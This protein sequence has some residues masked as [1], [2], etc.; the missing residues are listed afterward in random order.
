MID[1]LNKIKTILEM[2][3]NYF[4]PTLLTIISGLFSLIPFVINLKKKEKYKL[5]NLN[6]IDDKVYLIC[7]IILFVEIFFSALFVWISANIA[8]SLT[9]KLYQKG[10]SEMRLK[11]V[12]LCIFSIFFLII[13]NIVFLIILGQNFI[14]KI[15]STYKYIKIFTYIT[16]YAYYIFWMAY[17]IFKQ[18]YI[19]LFIEFCLISWSYWTI[20]GIDIFQSDEKYEYLY[21][22][23]FLN[24][25][26]I[27]KCD[28]MKNID[29]IKNV[30]VINQEDTQI[31]IKYENIYKVEYSNVSHTMYRI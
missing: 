16:L 5:L 15:L 10:M 6:A 23:I 24:S 2:D 9:P 8:I 13:Q 11:I 30:I 19:L 4:Y 1:T 14:N 26:E 21:A 3:G 29:R 17:Y 27:I 18:D 25:G 22:K 20:S 7:G 28:D 12:L 31:R